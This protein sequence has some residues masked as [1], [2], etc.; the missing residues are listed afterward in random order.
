LTFH[1]EPA[2]W[3][4]SRI[5][6]VDAHAVQPY[7]DKAVKVRSGAKSQRKAI[8]AHGKINKFLQQNLIKSADDLLP[9]PQGAA[10]LKPC[11]LT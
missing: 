10:C 9:T 2:T 8:F 3:I 4:L 1:F 11:Q 7:I 6:K 5:S